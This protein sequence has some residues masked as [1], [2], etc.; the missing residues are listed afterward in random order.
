M[1]LEGLEKNCHPCHCCFSSAVLRSVL[2]HLSSRY[3]FFLEFVWLQKAE[4]LRQGD[5]TGFSLGKSLGKA[6]SW[7]HYLLHKSLAASAL[8]E[9]SDFVINLIE[10]VREMNSQ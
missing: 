2:Y 6:S 3:S 1:P 9:K 7:N 10:F 4:K 5:Q 8:S